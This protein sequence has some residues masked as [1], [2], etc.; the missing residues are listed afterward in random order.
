MINIDLAYPMGRFRMP[1]A[2]SDA[3]REAFVGLIE[4]TPQA[5]RE[6]LQGL[7]EAQLDTP[8]RPGGWTIRQVVHHL[9]DSHM[10]AYIRFK[11][12]LTEEQPTILPYDEAL[13][14]QT[15]EARSGPIDL[16]VDLLASLHARWI[17]AIRP[18]PASAFDRSF[19]HPDLG[20]MS[21]NQQLAL[22]AWHGPHHVAHI[23]ALIE[24]SGWKPLR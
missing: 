6:A 17:A 20:V 14:A 2:V 4:G 18:L 23:T 13:W 11:L 19:R 22:Y 10:N 3:E 15:P 9:P 5:L 12:A 24:R 16:S 1:E 21:L 8:Y 7:D